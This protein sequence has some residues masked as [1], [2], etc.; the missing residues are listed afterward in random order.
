MMTLLTSSFF[1]HT[2]FIITM[3][4]LFDG[5]STS[6]KEE[7]QSLGCRMEKNDVPFW[8]LMVGDS[9][10]EYRIGL[11]SVLSFKNI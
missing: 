5:L 11:N 3:D 9:W 1:S 2:L 7:I 8:L 10:I 4:V 6:A